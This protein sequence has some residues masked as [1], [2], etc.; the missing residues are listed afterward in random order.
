MASFVTEHWLESRDSVV[1]AHGLSCLTGISSQT[2]DWTHVPCISWW[3]PIYCSAREVQYWLSL[4]SE[5][6]DNFVFFFQ[7][8]FAF[9][10]NMFKFHDG[11]NIINT[12][13]FIIG[14]KQTLDQEST[15]LWLIAWD[16]WNYRLDVRCWPFCFKRAVVPMA[17]TNFLRRSPSASA[18]QLS[19]I[20][21]TCSFE[22]RLLV[23]K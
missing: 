16:V 8:F 15:L 10:M 7:F 18:F 13:K 21:L 11:I 3:I 9:I 14:K 1:V 4:S 17:K 23:R 19:S 5:S 2:R 12:F 6:V 22:M 20:L